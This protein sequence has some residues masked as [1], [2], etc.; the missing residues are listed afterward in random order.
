VPEPLEVSAE[1]LTRL[2]ALN[3]G[4][5]SRVARALGSTRQR[6]YRMLQ[7]LEIDVRSYR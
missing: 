2:L 4:N 1:E 7:V 6:V 3:G 5:V